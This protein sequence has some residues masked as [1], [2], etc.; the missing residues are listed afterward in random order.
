[1][2]DEIVRNLIGN[3]Q[4]MHDLTSPADAPS[5]FTESDPTLTELTELSVL[6][7]RKEYWELFV[8]LLGYAD[9]KK[10]DYNQLLQTLAAES[11][12]PQQ[13][14]ESADFEKYWEKF[15]TLSSDVITPAA[16]VIVNSIA[17]EGLSIGAQRMSVWEVCRQKYPDDPE[18]FWECLRKG[19]DE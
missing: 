12:D 16:I 18:A 14:S 2:K 11:Q 17:R 10:K 19:K 6:S 8:C 13:T 9:E 3:W 1:M 5:K 7:G 4:L 15:S